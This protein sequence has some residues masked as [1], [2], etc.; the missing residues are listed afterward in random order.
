M[1]TTGSKRPWDAGTSTGDRSSEK[2]CDSEYDS[3]PQTQEQEFP[4]AWD[5]GRDGEENEEMGEVKEVLKNGLDGITSKADNEWA[6]GNKLNRAP[7][8]GLTLKNIGIVGLPLSV[9][10]ARRI[11]QEA[12]PND[13]SNK[14][15]GYIVI[16]PDFFET[17]NPDWLSYVQTLVSSLLDKGLETL[18]IKL[19]NLILYDHN[20][21]EV[22][23]P[24]TSTQG[25]DPY[26]QLSIFLPS[27]HTGGDVECAL[28]E[29]SKSFPTAPFSEFDMSYLASYSD[30]EQR[31][32]PLY[33]GTRLQLN[34]HISVTGYEG[35]ESANNLAGY[36]QDFENELSTWKRLRE[37]GDAPE[38]L[39]YVLNDEY[40]KEYLQFNK[41]TT[42]D[43][44]K[45][46]YLQ[47][48][49]KRQGVRPFL[50]QMT[51]SVQ[52]GYGHRGDDDTVMVLNDLVDFSGKEVLDGMVV[53]LP[54]SII[55]G[56]IYSGRDSDDPDFEP[57]SEAEEERYVDWV[58]VL[59]PEECCLEL[60]LTNCKDEMIRPWLERLMESLQNDIPPDSARAELSFIVSWYSPRL[61]VH[62][63][64]YHDA[65]Y[66]QPPPKD[67][68]IYYQEVLGILIRASILLRDGGLFKNS[69][70][71]DPP[72]IKQE[73]FLDVGKT[74]DNEGLSI[75]K[76]GLDE[77]LTKLGSL[78]RRYAVLKSLISGFCS[79]EHSVVGR[80][81]LDGWVLIQVKKALD[82]L[83]TC[84]SQDAYAMIELGEKY[85]AEFF[86]ERVVPL[87]AIQ[88]RNFDFIVTFLECIQKKVESGTISEQT[89]STVVRTAA[90]K[91]A[92]TFATHMI[93]PS[94]KRQKIQE[95]STSNSSHCGSMPMEGR[96]MASVIGFFVNL[97]LRE[98][99][100]LLLVSVTDQIRI[101][102]RT[103]LS[104]ILVPFLRDIA[105]V[106]RN[107][108]LSPQDATYRQLFQDGL[109]HIIQRYVG[110][111]PT[112]PSSWAL[113]CSG[114]GC[115]DCNEQ[116]DPFLRDPYHQRM[117]F[118]STGPRR[119]HLDG[120][121]QAEASIKS[122]TKM[123]ARAPHI[124]VLEKTATSYHDA[125]QAW[126]DRCREYNGLIRS[127]GDSSLKEL[128]CDRYNDLIEPKAVRGWDYLRQ[129][130]A[131][132]QAPAHR[133]PKIARKSNVDIIDLSN[134]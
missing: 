1:Y 12:N 50:S 122:S 123:N 47:E 101:G 41:L 51:G 106:M 74:L 81:H 116:L 87:A 26:I 57:G 107:S 129:P 61:R 77:M 56:D 58:F 99:S 84:D 7:N 34:Y 117:E 22:E 39:A 112:C 19:V 90:T 100:E 134:E 96:R 20:Y 118:K 63:Q 13:G 80:G 71:K 126:Q 29:S 103:W 3:D 28:G 32:Q 113:P 114:C 64:L 18:Q 10:E 33:T 6:F 91:M 46:E 69:V 127:I 133:E 4:D 5:M 131:N 52:R 55:Q 124:L 36:A 16:E 132:I 104:N 53:I 128:L 121:L 15:L 54:E 17:R 125:L 40:S 37:S 27:L 2:N 44:L 38:T 109:A 98:E 72:S 105:G 66:G 45:A 42:V 95:D 65:S 82:S 85:G 119:D 62:P 68:Q 8:P 102:D 48:R 35:L 78:H 60:I 25:V 93:K 49:C 86:I 30:V 76:E 115:K 23:S 70:C 92:P 111:E 67:P 83:S 79:A 89:A 94:A 120:R 97:G 14:V 88:A 11:R 73:V 130:L 21:S 9:L 43:Q 31:S 75:F 110:F 24:M 59:V 108:G